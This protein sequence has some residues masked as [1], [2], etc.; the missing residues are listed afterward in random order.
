MFVCAM[1]LLAF[2]FAAPAQSAKYIDA[3]KHYQ[4]GELKEALKLLREEVRENPANDAACYY[5]A[6]ICGTDARNDTETEN[7]L[8]RA[9]ELSPDNFW[10]RYS[11]SMFYLHS[12]RQEL[13]VPM[14]EQLTADF[15]KKSDL[16]FDL[17]QVYLSQND[18]EKALSTLDKIEAIR[19][20][21]EMVGLTRTASTPRW[22]NTST[23]AVH[24]AWP[25]PLA[26][27]TPGPT[28]TR[29]PWPTT[30]KPWPWRPTTRPPGTEK[31]A[32]T[33]CSAST[34]ASSAASRT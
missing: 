28:A 32:S 16:Y 8:K 10:Y 26:T 29:P 7:W 14:L 9:I 21:S 13:A 31:P 24:R 23:N 3:L 6:T 11:L 27:I 20:K 2:P 22:D 12:D 1:L 33:R 19:G 5:I 34:T 18:I 25:P 4:Q 17:I 30:R 15:P